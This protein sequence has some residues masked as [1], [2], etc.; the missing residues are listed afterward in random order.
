[1]LYKFILMMNQSIDVKLEGIA[2]QSDEGDF[3]RLTKGVNLVGLP[4]QVPYIR[5]VSDVL[6]LSG[7][8][9]GISSIIVLSSEGDF[10]L[11]SMPGDRGDVELI[12]GQA[13][14]MVARQD[15]IFKLSGGVRTD[16]VNSTN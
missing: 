11:V 9:D 13:L 6:Q 3:I 1:M 4:V 12:G 10:N 8:K 15:V 2:Y 14:V 5:K 7:L 16:F